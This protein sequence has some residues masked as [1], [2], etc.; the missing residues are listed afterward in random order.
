MKRH[1][2]LGKAV[3]LVFCPGVVAAFRRPAGVKGPVVQSRGSAEASRVSGALSKHAETYG[4]NKRSKCGIS[5]RYVR[6][7]VWKRQ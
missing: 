5:V 1:A 2:V 7:T 6:K 3:C 4:S